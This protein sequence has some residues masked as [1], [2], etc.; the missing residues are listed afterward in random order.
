M[1]KPLSLA[2][3]LL[4]TATAAAQAQWVAGAEGDDS[5]QYFYLTRW[6]R[7]PLDQGRDLLIWVT[8]SYLAYEVRSASGTT[9]VRA[10]GISAGVLHRWIG[11]RGSFAAGPGFESRWVSRREP[12]GFE[13]DRRDD[14]LML[15]SHGA[16]RV[17]ER[18][19]IEGSASWSDPL[20]WVASRIHW[21][22]QV[23]PALRVGPE[24]GYHGNDDI[25]I[26]ELG[27]VA[28][29]G[30]DGGG[31]QFRAGQARVRHRGGAEES[32][33]YFVVGIVR[34]F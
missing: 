14:G 9:D 23:A 25:R 16:Y 2:I 31:L 21:Q 12:G 26:R 10:P 4:L 20:D 18:G 13:F 27:A 19:T 24:A 33:P 7:R 17:T 29:I 32:A 30:R 34:R 15:Q 8:G 3:A 6:E 11:P 1:R 28:T 5:R 22:Q